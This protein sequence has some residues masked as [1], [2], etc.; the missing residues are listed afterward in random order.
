MMHFPIL[1]VYIYLFFLNQAACWDGCWEANKHRA[2][3][4]AASSMHFMVVGGGP[5]IPALHY[6]FISACF[7]LQGTVSV[8]AKIKPCLE[9]R[10]FFS[11][12][13][14]N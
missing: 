3:K 11:L 2:G 9:L 10:F 1:N 7:K 4:S 6:P 12:F 13:E 8:F 5:P 14:R